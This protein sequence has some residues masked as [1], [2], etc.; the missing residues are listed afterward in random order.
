[1]TDARLPMPDDARKPP[2][3]LEAERAVLGSLLL[4]GMTGRDP[5]PVLLRLAARSFYLPRHQHIFNAMIAVHVGGGALDHVTVN[6]EIENQG[7]APQVGGPDGNVLGVL[8]ELGDHVPT[9]SNVQNYVDIVLRKARAR[10]AIHVAAELDAAA[11]TE[12][13]GLPE[14]LAATRSRIDII[15]SHESGQKALPAPARPFP[16]VAVR[17]IPEIMEQAWL[18]KNLIPR[19]P[20][21]GTAGYIFARE[22]ARKSLLLADLALSVTTG[23]SAVGGAFPVHHTGATLG[24][25]AED[26][27]AETARRIRRMARDRGVEVP[28]NLRLFDIPMLA[29]DDPEHQKRLTDT[30]AGVPDLALAWFDPMIRLHRAN[31]NRAEELGPIHTFLRTLARTFTRAVFIFAH[32]AGKGDSDFRGSTEY[33]AFGDFNLYGRKVDEFTTEIHR[34]EFKGGPAGVPFRYQVEDGENLHGPTMRL[35]RQDVPRSAREPDGKDAQALT[36][37]RNWRLMHPEGTSKECIHHLRTKLR[38]KLGNDTFCQLWSDA[39]ED[40]E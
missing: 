25:F 1:M 15:E 33:G 8:V 11:R 3:D 21:D 32:H 35:V 34:L 10:E 31:D 7:R 22:K 5:E 37:I 38:M 30:L 2:Q 28:D 6:A 16:T 4:L 13:L 26:P 12:A 9:A 29:L 20:D 14:A 40:A 17:D 19:F 39:R 23:T 36:A 18:V 24:F 27:R